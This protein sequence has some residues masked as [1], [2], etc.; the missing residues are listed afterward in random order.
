MSAKVSLAKKEAAA[1]AP[2]VTPQSVSAAPVAAPA[3]AAPASGNKPDGLALIMAR[4]SF[5]TINANKMMIVFLGQIA[6]IIAMS[7]VIIKLLDF[8]DS[9]D[10][11]FPAQADNTLI[12]ERPLSEPVFSNEQIRSWVENAVTRTMTF[13]FYDHLL[14][15][16]QSRNYFTTQGWASF[17]SALDAAQIFERIGAVQSATIRPSKQVVVARLR[18]GDRARIV[19][20]GLIGGRYNWKV[21]LDIDITFNNR[22]TQ[23]RFTWKVDVMVTR[24]PTMES[25]EGIGISQLVAEAGS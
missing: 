18:S 7:V 1:T 9:R 16:Q 22:G 19:Q 21:Q 20:A 17:T 10:H 3:A 24:L 5:Y 2:A 12:L 8:T 14:R 6:L 25:R 23:T 13:G 11:F 4:N 15:L